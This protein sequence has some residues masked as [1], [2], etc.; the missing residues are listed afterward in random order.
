MQGS[1]FYV[2]EEPFCIWDF[3]TKVTARQFL[4]G[5]DTDYFD[6]LLNLHLSAEDEKRAAISLRT[7]LHHALETMFSLIGAFV[8]APDCPHAWIPKCNNTTLRRLLEAIDREDRTLF[9]KLPIERVS[10][11]QIA[12][13]V[14]RQTDFGSDKSKCTAEKF[15]IL[16]GRLSK[17]ALDEDFIDE[18]NSIKHGFRISSGGFALAVGLEQTYGQAPPPE[19]MQLLGRSEFG[20]SFLTI[21]AAREEKGDRNLIS[22]RVA[23]NWSIEQTV[24]LLHLVS[25]SLK[26][27]VSALKIRNGLKGSECRFH[28]PVDEKDFDVPWNYSPTVPRMSFNEVIPVEEIPPLS[29]KDLITDFRAIK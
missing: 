26:N 8:Q 18:Y 11:L 22:K 23:L 29:R 17:M 25:M 10:W 14:F 2:H 27:V 4:G 12:T 16:W 19:E 13:Q 3:E 5:I 15:G 20:R 1:G 9:T 28:R 21:G 24:A 7:T 6:Y